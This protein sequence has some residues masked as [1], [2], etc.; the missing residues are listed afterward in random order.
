MKNIYCALIDK[1]LLFIT[2]LFICANSIAGDLV[3]YKHEGNTDG[4]TAFANSGF[5]KVISTSSGWGDFKQ[6]FS[7]GNGVL[8]G[9]K[10]DGSLVW[11]KHEGFADGSPDFANSGF[12]VVISASSGWGDFKKV[13]HGGDGVL[14]GVKEDGSLVWYKHEGN[15]DGS[16]AFANGGFEKVISASSGWGDFKRLFHGGGG[17]LYG[18][19]K[20]TN[21]SPIITSSNKV[22]AQEGGTVVLTVTATDPDEDTL[23]YSISDGADKNKFTINITGQL[24]FLSAPTF[25]SPEDADGNN[26]YEVTIKVDDGKEGSA[27]QAIQVTVTKEATT[28]PTPTSSS[29]GG[30]A[31]SWMLIF[32]SGL[33]GFR[34]RIFG[35]TMG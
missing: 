10:Q 25:G 1:T 16:T 6:L 21:G 31:L 27:T 22:S 13:F 29:G 11:Y 34:R 9:V 8:Y 30:G 17:V 12:E 15:A 33:L 26:V 24:A 28:T 35:K 7:G 19:K 20:E 18:L 3:W 4:S 14:Y 32:T 23:S 2:L 5:E